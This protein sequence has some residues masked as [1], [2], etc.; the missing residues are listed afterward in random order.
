MY[1]GAASAFA[2]ASTLNANCSSGTNRSISYVFLSNDRRLRHFS[3]EMLTSWPALHLHAPRIVAHHRFAVK[4][5]YRALFRIDLIQ[6]AFQQLRRRAVLS[7]FDIVPFS[8]CATSTVAAPLSSA[9][10]CSKVRRNHLTELL[11]PSRR[12][13]PGVKSTSALP[14]PVKR[15]CLGSSFAY[16][17][18]LEFSTSCPIETWPST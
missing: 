12:K 8:I 16:P 15:N 14:L 2:S 6:P 9:T 4:N 1:E 11:S 17:I 18:E 7:H 3:S 10:S 13:T 5:A